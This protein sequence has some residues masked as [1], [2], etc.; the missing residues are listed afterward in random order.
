[1][2]ARRIAKMSKNIL[3]GRNEIHIARKLLH[4]I[5]VGFIIFCYNYLSVKESIFF[6]ALAFITTITV[7]CLRK[8]LLFLQD[9]V[10]N[11]FGQF[12]R[13]QELH[14]LSGLSWLLLG[15]LIV[16]VLFPVEIVTL[17][18][19]MLA[20]GDPICNLV[21]IKYGKDK[22]IGHKSFQ[23]TLAGFIACS[24]VSATYFM[25][26]EIMLDRWILV[27]LLSGFIGAFAEAIPIDLDDNFIIPVVNAI[28]LW[29][30]F[31]FFGS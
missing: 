15:S 9:F 4:V 20:I 30:L 7:D 31:S 11:I 18:L 8:R 27:S 19:L 13:R 22:L 10:I 28:L 16:V 25:F 17:S 26:M 21:G 2:K 23:G 24:I 1:M 3:K 6:L 14:Q 5:G 29:G 12:M